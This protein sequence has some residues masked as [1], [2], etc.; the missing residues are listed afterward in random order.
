MRT[1]LLLMGVAAA[2]LLADRWEPPITADSLPLALVG[3][4]EPT[5]CLMPNRNEYAQVR[6]GGAGHDIGGEPRTTGEWAPADVHGGDV[7]P[8]RT[9]FDP[10]P[11]FDGVA[12]DS[13]A[14]RTFFTDSSLSSVLS[15]PA[16]AGANSRETTEHETRVMGPDTG[17]GF[18]AGMDVDP[19]RR[20]VYAVNNDGGGVVVFGYD[21]T[22]PVRPVRQLETPHQSWDVSISARR[23][24]VAISVQ[25]LSG[26]VIYRRGASD[27][28]PPLRSIRGYSTGLADPHGLDFDDSRN[29]LVVANHG[30]W[31]ELRPYSPYDRLSHEPQSYQPG[32]FEPPSIKVFDASAGGDVR[33]L[34][35]IA[36]ARTG[37]NWPMGVEVDASRDEI[38]V[39]N[40]GDS[41]VRV[42]RRSASGDV[43]PVRMIKGDRT[44]IVGPVDVTVDPTRD[45]LWVANYA[46]HSAVVFDRDAS[47]NATP[48]RI[49]RNA[50]E[51]TPALAFTNA[52]A[53]A[54]DS[55]R[56]ALIV[57]N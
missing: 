38:I 20:E 56:D 48:K 17:I 40:Y 53:A 30:N 41:S 28:Q 51:G 47:G 9:V 36:G 52:S 18:V 3:S 10:Y 19:Q 35:S 39:A 31:T 8:A 54:Y 26:I 13:E 6:G 16:T 1:R 23:N 25:Q 21:Q 15:Y 24:E 34:R 2:W 43:E 37:L 12:V 50:P 29:E 33:P 27:M 4:R 14:G 46:D 44:Q 7:M 32:R 22:G 45:E 11:T 57:P 55:K 5:I 49:V 42:F